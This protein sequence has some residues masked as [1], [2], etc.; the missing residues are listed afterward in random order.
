[1]TIFHYNRFINTADN[2]KINT[3]EEFYPKNGGGLIISVINS[4]YQR[5]CLEENT[6]TI[7]LDLDCD[8]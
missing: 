5:V 4:S 1:M 7:T 3:K 6:S 8:A 2:T